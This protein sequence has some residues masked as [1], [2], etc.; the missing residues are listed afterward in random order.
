MLPKTPIISN[1]NNGDIFKIISTQSDKKIRYKSSPADFASVCYPL[2]CWLLKDV[3]KWRFLESGLSKSLTVCNFGNI[4]AMTI[5]FFWKSFKFDVDSIKRTKIWGK[6]F[7]V[8][9]NIIWI[10]N[11]K[12][13][14]SGT[15]HLSSAVNVSTNTP[16][17]SNS[18]KRVIFQMISPKSDEKIW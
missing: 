3:L 7:R 2:T 14:H 8:E 17:I 10:R 1:S 13:S 11:C 18:N 15:A 5:F 6:K 12:F 16:R 4:L 9:D